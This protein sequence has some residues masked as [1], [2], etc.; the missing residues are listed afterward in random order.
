MLEGRNTRRELV[1]RLIIAA[2]AGIASALIVVRFAVLGGDKASDFDWVWFAAR[3]LQDG[4]NPYELIGPGR[5]WDSTIGFVYPLTAPILVQPLAWLDLVTARVLFVAVPTSLL[6]FQLAKDGVDR[7][8]VLVSGSMVV[9]VL[10]VQWS[11]L[12]TLAGAFPMAGVILA[13]KPNLGLV[14]A[15]GYA[16]WKDF[17]VAMIGCV[18]VAVISVFVRPSWFGDWLQQVTGPSNTSSYLRVP[19]GFLLLLAL[20]RWRRPEARMLA[21]LAV[22]PQ[23]PG[24]SVLVPLFLARWRRERLALLAALTYLAPFL[25]PAM[26]H[27]TNPSGY[28]AAMARMTM[29]TSL[30]PVLAIVLAQ[31]NEG[32]AF[33]W[34]ERIVSRWPTWIAGHRADAGR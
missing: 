23:T 32:P 7:A 1:P 34:L 12:L 11:P 10:L 6:A 4:G 17:R 2:L 33:L 22:I 18:A 30:L 13:A 28:F 25:V 14:V 19:G 24:V 3:V 31:P 26:D 15:V 9:S 20:L 21:A 8:V 29:F 5:V 27:F 16:R